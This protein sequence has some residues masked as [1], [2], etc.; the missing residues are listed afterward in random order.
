MAVFAQRLIKGALDESSLEVN[1]EVGRIKDSGVT[2]A[3]L[4]QQLDTKVST[5]TGEA[6]SLY[7]NSCIGLTV[8]AMTN[9]DGSN[10]DVA[11]G[12]VCIATGNVVESIIGDVGSATAYR[13]TA[14]VNKSGGVLLVTVADES[15]MT[16]NGQGKRMSI[17]DDGYAVLMETA[18]DT[19]I[20]VEASG[21]SLV[22]FAT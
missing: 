12:E 4:E 14:V 5:D 18:N 1:N 6:G 7:P 9:A 2:N 17:V 16:I 15:N 11:L 22:A 3:K 19:L 20:L 13:I 8:N 21:V 10:D